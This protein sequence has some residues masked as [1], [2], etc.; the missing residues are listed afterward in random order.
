MRRHLNWRRGKLKQSPDRIKYND[1]LPVREVNGRLSSKRL[2]GKGGFWER[3][4]KCAKI[5]LKKVVGR[6]CLSYEVLCTI[7]IE[8]TLNNHPTAY[9]YDEEDGISYPLTPTALIYG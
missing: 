6:T 5:C 3:K 1:I 7:L 8:A 2:P 9:M 4:V